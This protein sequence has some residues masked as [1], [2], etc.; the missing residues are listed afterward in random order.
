MI[1]MQ[2]RE[3]SNACLA[4][5][6]PEA[7]LN[8]MVLQV[9][10]DTRTLRAG[11][12]FVALKGEKFDGHAFLN[13]AAEKGAIAAMVSSRIENSP[14]PL[15]VAPDTLVALGS[16]GRCVRELSSACVVGITGS[17]GKTTTKALT[18]L[19]VSSLSVLRTA[20]NQ[21][22]EIGVP[23][24][25]LD[26][27][28]H[29]QAAIVEMAMRAPGEIAYL[30]EIAQPDIAVITNIGLSHIGRLGSKEAIADAKAE[31]FTGLRPG[32][33]AILN[34]DEPFFERL[35]A[36]AAG[37]RVV[38][39]G[40]SPDSDVSACDVEDHG[41]LGVSFCC[42]ASGSETQ[43]SLSSGGVHLVLNSLA[44]IAVA[45]A[46]QIP[47]EDAASALQSFS[48][49]AGRGALLS[50]ADGR[51]VIDDAYNASPDSVEAA[52]RQLASTPEYPRRVAVLG[53]MLEMGCHAEGGHRRVGRAAARYGVNSLVCVGPQ[54][55]AMAE[56][57][58]MAGMPSGAVRWYSDSL[59]AAIDCD[60][61]NRDADVILVKGS[62]GTRMRVIVEA[63]IKDADRQ[64]P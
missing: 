11:S 21:N 55:I 22:N 63:L 40:L 36:A 54:S 18:S 26:L 23:L 10:T 49:A 9:G 4:T 62:N 24:T 41:I 61:W 34:R 39:F 32:G 8:K 30:S 33:V 27:E 51:V 42:R 3:M 15:L 14:L 44:A 31:I 5:A 20:G 7:P 16:L 56:E 48:T 1:P 46:L 17:V 38:S 59:A 53:D 47:L 12:L 64:Q 28:T 6:D 57:A 37:A 58:R 35:V 2:L 52:L 60:S 45:I 19:A 25:L 13:S 29:H 50:T 43:V